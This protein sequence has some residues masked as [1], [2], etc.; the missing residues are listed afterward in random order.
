MGPAGVCTSGTGTSP[1]TCTV[2]VAEMVYI[3][4]FSVS[5]LLTTAVL[6]EGHSRKPK[7]VA[8]MSEYSDM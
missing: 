2:V 4:A 5:G 3:L 6:A 7:R 1:A 8:A